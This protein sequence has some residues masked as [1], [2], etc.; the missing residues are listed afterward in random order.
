M[1]EDS[2]VSMDKYLLNMT[3]T[4]YRELEG[5]NMKAFFIRVRYQADEIVLLYAGG[6]NIRVDV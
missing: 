2:S 6:P 5:V 4:S 1:L 3:A